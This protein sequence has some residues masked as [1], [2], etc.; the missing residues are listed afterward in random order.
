MPDCM[1]QGAEADEMTL[2]D[3]AGSWAHRLHRQHNSPIYLLHLPSLLL[4]IQV[5]IL[6]FPFLFASSWAILCLS[7][8]GVVFY[9]S[10]AV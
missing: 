5:R 9:L 2:Q 10:S 6:S 8:P 3:V 1:D 4:E 7:D